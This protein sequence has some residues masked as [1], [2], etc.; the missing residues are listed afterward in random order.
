MGVEVCWIRYVLIGGSVEVD[1]GVSY[2]L[3]SH[4]V[5]RQLSIACAK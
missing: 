1:F 5:F 2:V 3:K 4:P